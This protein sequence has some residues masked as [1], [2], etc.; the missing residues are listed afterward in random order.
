MRL[1]SQGL[2]SGDSAPLFPVIRALGGARQPGRFSPLFL[3]ARATVRR[4]A[5]EPLPV[6]SAPVPKA[7]SRLPAPP[8]MTD[9]LLQ[10]HNQVRTFA[11]LKTGHGHS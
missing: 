4:K 1:C 9:S 11:G 2:Q 7:T 8:K 5:G 3:A 10:R 6:P